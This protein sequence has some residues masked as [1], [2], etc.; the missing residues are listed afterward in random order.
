[1]LSL[2]RE[3]L[4]PSE[5]SYLLPGLVAALSLGGRGVAAG[6]LGDVVCGGEAGR[7]DDEDPLAAAEG[8][9]LLTEV[10]FGASCVC[11]VEVGDPGGIDPTD[12]GL[13]SG[14][15]LVDT[16]KASS[17]DNGAKDV[18]ARAGIGPEGGADASLGTEGVEKVFGN[19]N[20][21]SKAVDEAG[22]GI[23]GGEKVFDGPNA[24]S[25]AAAGVVPGGGAVI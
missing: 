6:N 15:S 11:C 1:M 25:N 18:A 14:W 9:G 12:L 4:A 20:A 8:E 10:P 7:P 19:P 21:S 5:E 16:S 22:L 2:E 17:K 24:S 13:D 23:E 3:E